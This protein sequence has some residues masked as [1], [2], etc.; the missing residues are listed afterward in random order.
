MTRLE[1]SHFFP[2][3]AETY[4][5]RIFFDAEFNRE[6]FFNKLGFREWEVLS[7]EEENGTVVRRTVRSQPPNNAPGPVQKLI[8]DSLSYVDEGRMDSDGHWRFTVRPSVMAE[9]IHISGDFWTEPT[10][11]GVNRRCTM[12]IEVKVFGIGRMVETTIEKEMR[13]S[14]DV[15]ATETVRF[16]GTLNAD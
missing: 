14:Y 13:H 9:K 2:V 4:W 15:A 11:G 10:E 3:D 6:L 1:V 8:G 12:E 16:I 7:Q 5:N